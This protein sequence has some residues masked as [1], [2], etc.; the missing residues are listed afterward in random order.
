MARRR[1]KNS[2][3]VGWDKN[4]FS[5]EARAALFE[6][7]NE[8]MGELS[9]MIAKEANERAP[10]LEEVQPPNSKQP[11]RRGPNKHGEAND[12]REGPI[13]G[14]IFAQQSTKVLNTWLVC[15]PAWYSHFIEYG[16]VEHGID[17]KNKTVLSFP[18]THGFSGQQIVVGHVDHPG[19][20]AK[21]F[22]RP[23]AD[24]AEEFLQQIL[25]ER[26]WRK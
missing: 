18:G 25:A 14:K 11:M 26:G 6:L 21:P 10:V 9:E 13:K 19:V 5:H 17:P 3:T 15:S 8:V 23:A 2:S 20:K 7:G 22:L 12:G 1:S 16:T 24:K 4:K